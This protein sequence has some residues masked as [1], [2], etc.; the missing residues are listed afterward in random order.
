MTIMENEITNTNNQCETR[1]NRQEESNF[2]SL[3]QRDGVDSWDT[4]YI[5]GINIKGI[6][7]MRTLEGN[8]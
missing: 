6:G 3:W 4:E 2:M 1:C 5:Q 7:K 8:G